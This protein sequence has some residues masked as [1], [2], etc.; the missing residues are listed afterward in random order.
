[1]TGNRVAHPLLIGLANIKMNTRS[2]ASSHAFSLLALLPVPKFI[3]RKKRMRGVLEDRLIHACLDLVLQPLKIAARV[4]IMM[5]DP[6]GNL[7]HCFTPLAAY[8]VDLPEARMMVCV[9]DKTSPLTTASYLEFGNE[10]SCPPRTGRLTLL[11]LAKVKVDPASLEEYFDACKRYRLNGV[12]EPFWR[13]WPLACPSIFLTPE[14]LHQWHKEFFD[15]DLCWAI[16]VLTPAEID[17]RMS[18]CNQSPA[19]VTSTRA[20]RGSL[21]SPEPNIATFND[22]LSQS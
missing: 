18:S 20:F 5:S 19:F 9:R 1:M 11:Q 8:I 7:R 22:T 15:H 10:T 21:K 13:D 3:H 17:F 12:A 16:H 4:G 6:V 14:M 2:K